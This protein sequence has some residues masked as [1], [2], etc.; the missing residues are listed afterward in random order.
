MMALGISLSVLLLRPTGDM[1]V[2]LHG[3]NFINASLDDGDGTIIRKLMKSKS[4]HIPPPYLTRR[5]TEG[6]V[7]LEVCPGDRAE[8]EVKVELA[9][10]AYI[11]IFSVRKVLARTDVCRV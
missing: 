1:S 4:I 10:R 5:W 7:Q 6:P 2:S 9:H 3:D 11:M 8:M